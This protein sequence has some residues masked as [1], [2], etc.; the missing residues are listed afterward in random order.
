M[1]ITPKANN[2]NKTEDIKWT[3]LNGHTSKWAGAH[4]VLS[5]VLDVEFTGNLT[6]ARIRVYMRQGVYGD[7][8][9]EQRLALDKLRRTKKHEKLMHEH[10]VRRLLK[11]L[12]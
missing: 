8:A 7:K 9:Q 3:S 5:H 6:D 11:G 4:Y 2:M 12:V 1:P 10:A